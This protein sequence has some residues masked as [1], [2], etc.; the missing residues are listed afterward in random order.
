MLCQSFKID[1]DHWTAE[2]DPIFIVQCKCRAD[3]NEKW[4]TC[5]SNSGESE[6]VIGPAGNYQ[7]KGWTTTLSLKELCEIR[8]A[9]ARKPDLALG[10]GA[11]SDDSGDSDS[12]SGDSGDS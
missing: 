11:S 9:R 4:Q 10:G 12:D 3:V 7:G 2:D 1:A 6:R 8:A 5:G